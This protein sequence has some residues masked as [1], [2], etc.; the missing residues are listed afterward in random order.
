VLCIQIWSVQARHACIFIYLV[1]GLCAA[2]S[3]LGDESLLPRAEGEAPT[4][5]STERLAVEPDV[6][7]SAGMEMV[8]D[9]QEGSGDAGTLGYCTR[10]LCG[11]QALWDC[12]PRELWQHLLAFKGFSALRH[13]IK[14]GSSSG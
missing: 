4:T 6:E 12:F 8:E 2:R 1:C 10:G 7:Q 11:G 13:S 14:T 3:E 9:A 5:R